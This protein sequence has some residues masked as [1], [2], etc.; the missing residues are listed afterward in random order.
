MRKF[1]TIFTGTL[2]A[3]NVL[4]GG[5]VTNN[6]QSAKFTRL[7]N[8]NAST[9]IDAV[10][11]NPSGLTK[12]GD[13]FYTSINNQIVSQT[14]TIGS[15]YTYLSG[16]N[17]GTISKEYIGKVS[18][19]VFPG[20]Y[21]AYK[22]GKLVLSAGF[23]PIGGGGGGKYNKGLP[24]FE[25][26]IADLV[27][28]LNNKGFTATQYSGDINF[29][30][31]SIYFGYQANASYKVNDLFSFSAGIR[32]V[33]AKNTYS[34]YI[35]NI[36]INPV[37]PAFGSKYTGDMVLAGDF[38]TDGANTLNYLSTSATSAASGL[39]GSGY[40]PTTPL[41]SFPEATV[42][43]V[44]KILGAAGIS[45]AGMNI[46]TAAASLNAVSPVFA[47]NAV[48]MA[49]YA[50]QTQDI[51][52]DVVQTGTGYTPILG[53]DI[54]PSENLNI[55]LK[56]E[57]KTKL[58]LTTKIK[59]KEDGGGLFTD[60]K[61]IIAD[62][63]AVL[64]AGVEFKPIDKLTVSSSFN[65]YFDK[66]VDYDGSADTTINMIDNNFLEYG[67]GA[68]YSLSEKLRV[69]AGWLATNTGVNSAYQSDQRYS[70]NTNSFGVGFGYHITPMI[71]FNLGGQYTLYAEGSKNYTHTIYT[72]TPTPVSVYETYKKRTFIV[73][74]GLD[75]AF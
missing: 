34:G 56:Y 24:S 46:G 32:M 29:E 1:L 30:G 19:P 53:V 69:S 11:Y 45:A 3:G 52:V 37:Y 40:P 66:N 48:V 41:S 62:M 35:K 15:N 36:S 47:K 27:P 57:F 12:L 50:N 43:A 25:T 38:F 28:L 61:K 49:G 42:T 71:D 9:G 39:T 75:F 31:S 17:S 22:Q 60:G 4:A 7:Q 5:L 33:S 20:V 63:P 23:N 55:A 65:I 14:R 70:T 51:Y 54:S 64:S 67:L 10:Y 13:G 58:E 72:S 16:T 44:T 8:R 74:V 68:E 2:I 26:M 21:V 59:N 18:A 6:N 73:G